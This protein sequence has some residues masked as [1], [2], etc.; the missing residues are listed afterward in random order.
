MEVYLGF[1]EHSDYHVGRV[2]DAIEDLG[3]LDDTLIFCI[4]GRQRRL[5]RRNIEWRV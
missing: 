5:G 3:V 4:I 1:M 2:I